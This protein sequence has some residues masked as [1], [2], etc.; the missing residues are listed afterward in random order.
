MLAEEAILDTVGGELFEPCVNSLA[1][2]GR[3]IA[4]ASPQQPR[5]EFNLIDFF[6]KGARLGGVSTIDMDGLRVAQVFNELRA[7]FAT[8]YLKVPQVVS[9]RFENAL[10]AYTAS[11]HRPGYW[12]AVLSID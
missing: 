4:I 3:Q 8:G 7:G 5:V 9:T 10:E 11:A 12:K 6:R 2:G 1:S